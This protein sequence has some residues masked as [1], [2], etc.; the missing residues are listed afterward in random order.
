MARG[1]R[2]RA[3][4]PRP[5]A[6][7]RGRSRL[8]PRALPSSSSPDPDPRDPRRP[9]APLP[10]AVPLARLPT[11]ILPSVGRHAER[12]PRDR[13]RVRHA[14]T[15][16]RGGGG[17]GVHASTRL[18][19]APGELPRRDSRPLPRLARRSRRSRLRVPPRRADRR[20][21]RR[22]RRH[23]HASRRHPKPHRRGHGRF[24]P[25]PR[26]EISR[27]ARVVPRG[28]RPGRGRATRQT[29]ARRVSRDDPQRVHVRARGRGVR[30]D[31]RVPGRAP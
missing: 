23:H 14:R 4:G 16:P 17:E 11:T 22:L 13:P 5:R 27:R 24:L 8:A 9:R 7:G 10:R 15:L 1:R 31:L 28:L 21:Q 19:A 2:R 20:A 29:R 25:P 3:M 26:R 18:D 12:H 6:N 30:V